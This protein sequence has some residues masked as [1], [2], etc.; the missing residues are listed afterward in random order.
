MDTSL[1]AVRINTI[2]I[3]RAV[4][5]KA[6]EPANHVKLGLDDI[7]TSSI[8]IRSKFFLNNFRESV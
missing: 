1:R 6:D 2:T 5:L 4:I 7:A 3:S 8:P